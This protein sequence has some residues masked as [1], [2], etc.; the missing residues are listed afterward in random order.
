MLLVAMKARGR[1]QPPFRL[2]GQKQ[3]GKSDE[4]GSS[5]DRVMEYIVDWVWLTIWRENIVE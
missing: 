5:N 2:V 3:N 4:E 1:I